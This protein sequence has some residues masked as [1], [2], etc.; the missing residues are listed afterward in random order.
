MH[1]VTSAD[2]QTHIKCAQCTQS[3]LSGQQHAE[4]LGGER[5]GATDMPSTRYN[6]FPTCEGLDA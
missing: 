1:L 3:S 5:L 4:E 6:K 2:V